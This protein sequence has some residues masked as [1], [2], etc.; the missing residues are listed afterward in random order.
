MT[1]PEP[2]PAQRVAQVEV[3][4]GVGHG[5]RLIDVQAWPLHIGRALDNQVVLPDPHVA[6]HHAVVAPDAQGQL[7]VTVGDSRNG[8]RIEQGVHRTHLAAH[9]D[10]PLPSGAR[11]H[12][13]HSRLALRLPHEPLPAELPLL[14]GVSG[15]PRWLLPGLA[16]LAAGW[17]LAA[18]WLGGNADTQWNEYLVPLLAGS[19]LLLVWCLVWGLASKLFTGRFTL[20]V[21]LRLA[22]VFAL[23]MQGLDLL[24][25]V[26]AFGL[27]WPSLSRLRPAVA[28]VVGAIWLTQHLWQ[29]LPKHP[30]A[31]AAWVATGALLVFAVGAVNAWR[32]HDRVL[33]ELYAS[34]LMPPAWR[35]VRG[36]TVPQLMEEL[37]ALEQPL[38]ERAA[39]AKAEDYER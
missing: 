26:L 5:V 35:L 38:R 25:M 1:A 14:R 22:L 24:L 27:D 36:A 29:V 7:R 3:V 2:A 17:L 32:R 18:R 16:V 9:Q 23:V 11:L 30:R 39:K 13:G 12:L 10:A 31:A 21:H 37:R 34:S 33:D 28:F 20:T 19:A 6:A 4:D 15:G 8:V